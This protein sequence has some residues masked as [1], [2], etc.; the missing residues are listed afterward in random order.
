MNYSVNDTA[1]SKDFRD[2][3]IKNWVT[4]R[5]GL[6]LLSQSLKNVLAKKII[7]LAILIGQAVYNSMTK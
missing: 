2:G 5:T 1:D 4:I 3:F 6:Y 7:N